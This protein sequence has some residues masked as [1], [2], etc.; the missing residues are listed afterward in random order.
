LKPST[1]RVNFLRDA[2][3]TGRGFVI[4]YEPLFA[5]G[6]R[7][8]WN[9]DET[10]LNSMKYFCVFCQRGL[11]SLVAATDTVLHLSGTVSFF[12]GRHI[13]K[14]IAIL[15]NPQS[16]GDLSDLEPYCF[17]ATSQNAWI[18]KD[19]WIYSALVFSA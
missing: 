4:G 2:L 7:L 16:A 5:C 18:T 13:L 14:P 6:R 11:L 10:Q 9:I 8:I 12:G 19:L 15:K 1:F 3:R 17:F